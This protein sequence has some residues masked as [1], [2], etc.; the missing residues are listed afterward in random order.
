MDTTIIEGKI[1]DQCY[2]FG[3]PSCQSHIYTVLKAALEKQINLVWVLD[4]HA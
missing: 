3:V 4:V 1:A 2:P